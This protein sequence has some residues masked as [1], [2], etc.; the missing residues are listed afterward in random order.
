MLAS[1]VNNREFVGATDPDS[2]MVARFYVRAIFQPFKSKL[3]NR[4]IFEDV[5][6]VEYHAAGS[7]LQ[8]MDV[9]AQEYHKQ[10]FSKQWAYYQA[11]HGKDSREVGTPLEQWTLLGPSD[12]ENLK[13]LK[14]FTIDN[15]AG[16]SDQQ[17]QTLGMGI[18]SMA[19]HILR[20]R[21]QAFIGAA[22][23]GALPQRQAEDIELLKKQIADLTAML[24]AKPVDAVPAPKRKGR[25]PKARV[26]NEQPDIT[27]PG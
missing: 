17:L 23:D 5:L 9:P 3:D 24:Q 27:Q 10:R 21:A 20:A 13:A 2:V 25:P 19:P 7:T 11:T 26:E 18:A 22:K 16:A 1:D 8:K 12:V 14:F 15:I 6:Y 4:Q